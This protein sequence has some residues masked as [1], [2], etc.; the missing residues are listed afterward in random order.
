M[1]RKTLLTAA[2][3]VALTGTPA[4]STAFASARHEDPI[5]HMATGPG[6]TA[7][8]AEH[9]HLPQ[10]VALHAADLGARRHHRTGKRHHRL[11]R[12]SRRTHV[13]HMHT[14]RIMPPPRLSN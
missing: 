5:A 2:V 3:M 10:T 8:H 1:H 11:A 14:G 13:M 4:V 6:V 9:A 12:H 7:V